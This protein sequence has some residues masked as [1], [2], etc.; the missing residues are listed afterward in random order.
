VN[1][2]RKVFVIGDTHFPFHHRSALKLTLRSLKEF[3]PDAVIQIGD[4]YDFFSFSR[5]ARGQNLITPKEEIRSGRKFAI[6]MWED[7]IKAAP[8]AKRYQIKG[9][10]DIRP[11]NTALKKAPELEVF[12]EDKLDELH[13]FPKVKTIYNPKE[14]L[15]IDDVV[16]I[17]GHL[18]FGAHLTHIRGQYNI[19]CGHLHRG[20]TVSINYDGKIRTE[21]NAGFLGDRHSHVLNYAAMK[22]FSNMTL[23]YAK[24]DNEGL[25][26]CPI[27]D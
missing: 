1:K 20:Q 9:N 23:G 19:M 25:R 24:V 14:E 16:Y 3:K 12:I 17:H 11:M 5:F 7:V 4:L 6:R 22:R 26:F 15:I 10:H 21:C 2:R 13:T 27:D 8:K 18:K